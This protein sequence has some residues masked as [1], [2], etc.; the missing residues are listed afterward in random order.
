VVGLDPEHA[1]HAEAQV[2][3]DLELIRRI[4][5][6]V[7]DAP[8]GFAPPLE[9]EGYTPSQI[10]YHAYLLIDGGFAK[11]PELTHMQ[12]EG[13]E[14]RITSLTWEGHDFAEAARDPERWQQVMKIVKDKGG[15]VTLD[16][17]KQ[18]LIKLMTAAVGL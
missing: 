1:R 9:I 2:K 3:R 5:F 7:E 15:S 18:L 11:G 13:P 17:V 10:G 8:T 6:A 16:V 14:A 4:L 12:S